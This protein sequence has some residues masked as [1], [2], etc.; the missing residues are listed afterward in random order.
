MREFD[1]ITTR[2]KMPFDAPRNLYLEYDDF[3]TS[4]QNEETFVPFLNYP[5]LRYFTY[6][7]KK[8]LYDT[9]AMVSIELFIS[10]FVLSL[11]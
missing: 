9:Y 4:E 7:Q 3:K 8:A 2:I 6:T 11:N 10:V 1:A 5:A